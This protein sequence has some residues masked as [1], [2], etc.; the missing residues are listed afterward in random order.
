[1]TQ[2]SSA[3][4]HEPLDRHGRFGPIGG[5]ARLEAFCLLLDVA[6]NR[7]EDLWFTSTDLRDS[8]RGVGMCEAIQHLHRAV[9]ALDDGA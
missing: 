5:D 6:V 4:N 3:T 8:P 1:M 2:L 7:L 9:A